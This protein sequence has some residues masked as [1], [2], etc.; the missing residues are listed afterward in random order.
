MMKYSL[1]L[2][3][4]D[5]VHGMLTNGLRSASRAV[6]NIAP[7]PGCFGAGWF[8]IAPL[9]SG[10]GVN[11]LRRASSQPHRS[12]DGL[13]LLTR[14][15]ILAR[16]R[17]PKPERIFDTEP[18]YK[19][20][21]VAAQIQ[22]GVTPDTFQQM[23]MTAQQTDHQNLLEKF[24]PIPDF[25]EG[26]PVALELIAE[27]FDKDQMA[28]YYSKLRA[29]L[30]II[31]E[32]FPQFAVF[33]SAGLYS[34]D[35][36][37]RG[38]HDGLNHHS[39][40]PVLT[41]FDDAST[42]SKIITAMDKHDISVEDLLKFSQ[43][44]E[45]KVW[46]NQLHDVCYEIACVLDHKLSYHLVSNTANPKVFALDYKYFRESD[47]HMHPLGFVLDEEHMRKSGLFVKVVDFWRMDKHS[48]LTTALVSDVWFWN[49]IDQ[50]SGNPEPLLTKP[51][52]D[53]PVLAPVLSPHR[54]ERPPLEFHGVNTHQG[55]S[56]FW[57]D[58]SK[59]YESKPA[60]HTTDGKWKTVVENMKYAPIQSYTEDLLHQLQFEFQGFADLKKQHPDKDIFFQ[61][62]AT[63]TSW[64]R[65]LSFFKKCFLFFEL[66]S[67]TV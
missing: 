43:S 59:M 29:H 42:K 5:D 48:R 39:S 4:S 46:R 51:L 52:R 62:R 36:I 27:G 19:F 26:L 34:T 15:E 61:I 49:L 6:K 24:P 45:L 67:C 1:V 7:R 11:D 60:S 57:L 20:K 44:E 14:E 32:K 63:G 31:E 3:L 8:A 56:N 18:L 9:R 28:P 40:P 38:L 25:E 53:D 12:M 47:M 2:L 50:I 35:A 13:R 30:N 41:N 23:V 54:Q 33:R 64:R 17:L 66:I 37:L 16:P 22:Q 65:G 21:I 58:I 10:F 55:W